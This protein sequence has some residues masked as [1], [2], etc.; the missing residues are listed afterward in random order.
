MALVSTAVAYKLG[1]AELGFY[2]TFINV[3]ALQVVFELGFGQ[4]IIQFISHE[5]P[6]IQLNKDKSGEIIAG[7]KFFDISKMALRWYRTISIAALLFLGAG[8]FWFLSRSDAPEVRWQV[9]WLA[10]VAANSAA[11]LSQGYLVITEGLNQVEWLAKTKLLGNFLRTATLLGALFAGWELYSLPVSVFVQAMVHF[12]S[13][14]IRWRKLFNAIG[15]NGALRWATAKEMLPMQWRLGISWLSGYVIFNLCVPLL[16]DRIGPEA[17]GQFGLSWTIQF[18]MVAGAYCWTGVNT[19][20]FGGLI[21]DGQFSELDALWNRG[22]LQSVATLVIFNV[23]F[24]LLIAFAPQLLF[25]KERM[26]RTELL[27]LLSVAGLCQLLALCQAA[28]LRAHKKEPFLIPTVLGA[29]LIYIVCTRLVQT[30]GVDGLVIGVFSVFLLGV[31]IN[32][33]IFRYCRK[34]WHE[35]YNCDTNI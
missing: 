7:S 33:F 29:A 32:S 10:I 6:A 5:A 3:L 13:I 16:F 20:R 17:A 27:L 4:C 14:Q 8:G 12:L 34:K 2:Y 1:P 9:P 23:C 15:K 28:Y 22:I 11:M 18:G 31:P 25:L 26:L 19:P 21:H 30:S 24:Y 35:T